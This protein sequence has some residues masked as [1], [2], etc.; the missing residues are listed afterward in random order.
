[1]TRL[2]VGQPILA[3]AAFQAARRAELALGG[4]R[5]TQCAGHCMW[6]DFRR[7]KGR[8]WGY[9][10]QDWLPHNTGGDPCIF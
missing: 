10:G 2:I 8:P 9:P 6:D 4:R 5:E 3:A 1:M 7:L